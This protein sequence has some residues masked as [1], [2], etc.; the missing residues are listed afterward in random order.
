MALRSTRSSVTFT[1]AF[2][3]KGAGGELPPGTYNVETDEE[4]IETISRTVYVRVA[5]L[6]YV[7]SIGMTRSITIDPDELAAALDRDRGVAD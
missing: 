4:I 2:D 3:L 1:K 5:T 7:R 6:L